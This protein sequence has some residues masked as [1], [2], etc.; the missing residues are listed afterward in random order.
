[1]TQHFVTTIRQDPGAN[2]TGIVVPPEIM[3]ALDSGKRPKVVVTLNGYSYRTTIAPYNG[4]YMI[5]LS[6]ENRTAAGVAGGDTLEVTLEL[7]T[8]PRIVEV[9]DDL[10]VALAEHD[11]QAAFDK[12]A[13]SV[14]KEHVRQLES[15]K[16]EETRQRR[17]N[18]IIT[19][20]AEK[21]G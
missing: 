9:P 19:K 16:A 21:K 14:R 3:D 11:L 7:D 4:E 18:S 1:M 20:L 15:A 6:Q 12:L 5:S 17:L 13:Y 8:A 2:T 10:A